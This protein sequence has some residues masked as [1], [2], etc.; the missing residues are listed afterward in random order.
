M[1]SQPQRSPLAAFV[2]MRDGKIIQGKGKA[3][4]GGRV[5]KRIKE[6][7]KKIKQRTRSE[8]KALMEKERTGR[9]E[10]KAEKSQRDGIL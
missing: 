3:G 7:V 4:G 9:E 1:P 5:E 2:A 10:W 6:G 8:S